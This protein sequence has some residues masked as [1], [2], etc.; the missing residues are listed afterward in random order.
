MLQEE[1]MAKILMIDDDPV[2]IE[3]VKDI[4]SSSHE[5]EI[6]TNIEDTIEL[7]KNNCYDL[8]FLDLYMPHGSIYAAEEALL[9]RETGY[10]LLKDIRSNKFGT[11]TKPNVPIIVLTFIR[12][13]LDP[14]L[15]NKVLKEQ[16]VVVLEKPE[17]LSEI[18]K[19][20][21]YMLKK[22]RSSYK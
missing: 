8:I 12:M 15:Q 21:D 4:L 19:R 2:S 17:S 22:A 16:P 6:A 5:V 18:V 11:E 7:V 10:L 14:D 9:G 13:K 20:V 3:D 1:K